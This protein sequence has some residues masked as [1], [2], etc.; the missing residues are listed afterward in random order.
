MKAGQGQKD[1][2]K[3]GQESWQIILSSHSHTRDNQVVD[4]FHK[5]IKELGI[6]AQEIPS[7][8]TINEKLMSLTGFQGVFVNG[9]EE[10]HSF[11]KMLSK[12]FFQWAIL[13]G[14]KKT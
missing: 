12:E 5:G 4:L 14:I 3:A 11:Y 7:L 6:N 1:F 13:Y 9:L 2:G 8:N 10:G